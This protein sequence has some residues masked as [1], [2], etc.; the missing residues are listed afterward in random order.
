MKKGRKIISI[1]SVIAVLAYVISAAYFL[2]VNPVDTYVVKQGTL[3]EE[4]ECFGY[5]IR[6]EV[7][8]KGED[9]QNGI[10]AIAS[11]GQR[12]AVGESIFRYYSDSEKQIKNPFAKAFFESLEPFWDSFS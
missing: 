5:I 3:T 7:V 11:E 8:V 9:Y 12:V 2:I 4:D 6:D 1:L 10:Y